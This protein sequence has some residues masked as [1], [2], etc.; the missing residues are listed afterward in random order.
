M[1]N[2]FINMTDKEF[3][4]HVSNW[5]CSCDIGTGYGCGHIAIRD[6]LLC[7]L[8]SAVPAG[9]AQ[10]DVFRAIETVVKRHAEHCIK[11]GILMAETIDGGDN[12]F[13]HMLTDAA[14]KFFA[15]SPA[16]A[17]PENKSVE[18]SD[19]TGNK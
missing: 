8:A 16:T 3:A 13:Q 1:T 7:R 12:T 17:Q 9:P 11:N 5:G 15:P 14:M 10:K 4:K 2:E 18:L 6:E 19:D